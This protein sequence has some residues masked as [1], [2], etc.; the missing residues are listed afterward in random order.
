M[1]TIH[2]GRTRLPLY[3]LIILD[4]TVAIACAKFSEL[5]RF[6]SLSML[7]PNA[8]LIAIQSLLAVL[9]SF[10]VGV[11]EP[12]RGRDLHERLGK[13][14]WAWILSFITL[15][16]FIVATKTA[17]SYSRLWIAIWSLVAV[18]GAV[19]CR[20]CVY[21]ALVKMRS[22][23]RNTRRVMVIGRGRNYQMILDDFQG[24]NSYGYNIDTV[25]PYESEQQAAGELDAVLAKNEHYDE[26]W[27]CLPLKDSGAV[28]SLIEAMKHSTVDVRFMPGLQDIPLLNHKVSPIGGYYSL[29]ISCSPLDGYSRIVKAIEDRVVGLII[30]LLILPVCALIALAIKLTS[31]GPVLFKQYRHGIDGKRI[32][33]YKFRSMSIHTEEQGKVTQA[34]KGDARITKVGAFLRRTSLDELPQF[35]NVIQ[36]KMSIVGPRPHALEHNEYYKEIV[37]S[38]MKRHKVKPGI[39]GLAQVRGFRGETDTL[40]KMQK[41]VECDLEYMDRWTLW[42]DF[43][44]IFM[45]VFKGFLNPNAY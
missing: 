42:L 9:C 24:S 36:G 13:V 37:E 35:F 6:Q 14:I 33:V 31:P 2:L 15:A 34:S 30:F 18:F 28:H 25:I 32:K 39:T 19:A 16:L 29:D 1:P 10:V 17:E 11:Y 23:G 40:E 44:I 26:C 27:I 38:Y 43:R 5:I 22:Q 21:K 41:R 7:W 12:W 20:I 8:N 3:L 4:F 45:T